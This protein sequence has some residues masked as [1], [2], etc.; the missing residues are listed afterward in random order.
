[1]VEVS[2]ILTD[3]HFQGPHSQKDLPDSPTQRRQTTELTGIM[4]SSPN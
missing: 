4:A 2:N 3:A 1:M